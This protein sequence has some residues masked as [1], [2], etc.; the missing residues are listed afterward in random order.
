MTDSTNQIS[1][2]PSIAT[3]ITTHEEESVSIDVPQQEVTAESSRVQEISEQ[4]EEL[5][6]DD[7]DSATTKQQGDLGQQRDQEGEDAVNGS[8]VP[9]TVDADVDSHPLESE[10]AET[11][12]TEAEPEGYFL[13][14]EQGGL[15][16]IQVLL[17]VFNR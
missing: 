8:A 1:Q 5:K 15:Y 13:D 7:P 16:L 4:I 2:P 12:G 9:V 6:V 3:E 17:E 11:R 10:V 14:P